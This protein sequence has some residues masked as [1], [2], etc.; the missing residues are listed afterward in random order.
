MCSFRLVLQQISVILQ[1]LC[2]ILGRDALAEASRPPGS[3]SPEGA[4]A[5]TVDR[6]LFLSP[7]QYDTDFQN[8]FLCL[9]RILAFAEDANADTDC[10]ETEV[11][12]VPLI[13]WGGGVACFGDVLYGAVD[14][15]RSSLS[16]GVPAGGSVQSRSLS[17]DGPCPVKPAE[18]RELLMVRALCQL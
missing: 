17:C 13:C 10:S 18:C 7:V 2:A 5:Q 16:L 12:L 14:L 3:P 4:A 15:P 8:S 9:L 6:G 1:G 11:C